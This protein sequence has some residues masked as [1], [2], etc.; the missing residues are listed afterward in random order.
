MAMAWTVGQRLLKIGFLDV[1]VLYQV[2]FTQEQAKA[3]ADGLPHAKL[4]FRSH[5]GQTLN[6]PEP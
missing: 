4:N 6:T 3:G 5:R 2:V 1:S